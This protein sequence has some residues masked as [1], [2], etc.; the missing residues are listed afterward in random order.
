MTVLHKL[1][2]QRAL[3]VVDEQKTKG[4]PRNSVYNEVYERRNSHKGGD[5]V[6][7]FSG[8]PVPSTHRAQPYWADWVA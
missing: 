6:L 7:R 3:I 4:Y 2:G 8:Y 5:Q 1:R